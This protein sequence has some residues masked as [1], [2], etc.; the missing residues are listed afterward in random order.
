MLR[1]AGLEKNSLI[2]YPGKVSAILF[3]YGCNLNCPYCHN[4]E[5]V[6]QKLCKENIVPHSYIFD[7][8]KKRVGKLD[9][10][11]ITGGEPLIHNTLESFIDK[12]KDMGYLVKLDTNGF[13]PEKLK[14]LIDK[15]LIDYIAMDIKY[16]KSKY[17]QLTEKKDSTKKI[18]NSINI[19][20]NSG[21]NY[22]FRTTYVKFIH[23]IDSVR[24]I[25]E[26]I[27]GATNYYIQNFRPGKTIDPLL[28]DSCSFTEEELEDIKTIMKK[29]VKNVYIR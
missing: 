22:E 20:M 16:P 2:D 12:I 14:A 26:M 1:I 9:A 17:I 29:Y 7:F 28:N 4:P 24:G 11:V 25:G 13:Y 3:T 10:V 23:D 18:L 19:I 5:L 15:K 21:L 6:T 8:L 27:E